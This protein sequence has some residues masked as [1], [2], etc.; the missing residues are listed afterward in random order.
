MRCSKGPIT[1]V[2]RW[3]GLKKRNSKMGCPGEWKHGPKPAVC[4]SYLILSHT[5]VVPGKLRDAKQTSVAF[6]SDRVPKHTHTHTNTPPNIVW[7]SLSQ[8][9]VA[10]GVWGPGS[11]DWV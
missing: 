9:G 11:L 10:G 8:A 7:F 5:Q 4:P 6:R 2:D 3:L 1:R